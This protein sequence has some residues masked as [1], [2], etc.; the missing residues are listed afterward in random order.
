MRGPGRG[1]VTSFA[2]SLALTSRVASCKITTMMTAQVTI[3][4]THEA[5]RLLRMIAAQT[6]EKQY[7]VLER[8][9]GDEW[10]CLR[11]DARRDQRRLARTRGTS[12][13]ALHQESH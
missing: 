8:L 11:D 12:A 13:T 4:T 10:D 7:Q 3:K 6:G 5:R 2:P 9:L 1:G